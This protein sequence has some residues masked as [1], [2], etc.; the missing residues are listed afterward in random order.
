MSW[1]NIFTVETVIK[2]KRV[3]WLYFLG[4]KS[5]KDELFLYGLSLPTSFTDYRNSKPK[6]ICKVGNK[7]IYLFYSIKD[8]DINAIKDQEKIIFNRINSHSNRELSYFSTKQ[9][10]Q[11]PN[12]CNADIPESPIGSTVTIDIFHS[13]DFYN[14]ENGKYLDD[15]SIFELQDIL[16]ALQED[17]GQSFAGA[18]SKR[19]GC[20]EY[21]HVK[22]WAE[23][24]SPFKIHTD[25]K[26]PNKYYFSRTID[27]EDMFVHLVVYSRSDE[28]LLVDKV[29]KEIHHPYVYSRHNIL[30]STSI[31]KLMFY[32]ISLFIK[33]TNSEK[34]DLLT[35]YVNKYKN[36]KH[37][38]YHNM[39]DELESILGQI[40]ENIAAGI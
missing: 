9:L 39:D 23:D 21:G 35:A 34:I 30:W 8:V 27:N 6:Q 37:V 5:N 10:I 25:K 4:N 38:Y 17:T 29:Y 32:L 36:V 19:L 24:L 31:V 28:I 7:Q 3:N 16:K 18:Y 33:Y 1:N 15:N 12:G 11:V 22:D 40:A 13:D 2:S 26:Q 14:Y 20:F